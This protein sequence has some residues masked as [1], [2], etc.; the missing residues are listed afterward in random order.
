WSPYSP[1]LNPLDYSIW[2]I[3]EAKVCA[4]PHNSVESLKHDLK[5]AWNEIDDNTLRDANRSISEASRSLYKG[6][7][8]SFR[9]K[10]YIT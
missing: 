2:G 6:K 10:P 8:R 7:W 5:K 1:N 9:K 3:L 4:K